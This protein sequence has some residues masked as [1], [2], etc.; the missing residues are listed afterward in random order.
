MNYNELLE[1]AK[2]L[3]EEQPTAIS[4]LSNASAFLNDVLDNLNWVGFYLYDGEVLHVGP[5]QG[6]VAC[7]TIALGSGVCG[8]AA[9]KNMTMVIPDVINH[10]N[11]IACDANSRSETVVPLFLNGKLYGVLDIDS[12]VLNRFD[13]ALVEFLEDFSKIVLKRLTNYTL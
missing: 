12:P 6:Q 5:F 4:L 7:A 1:T 8:E 9:K 3:L 11:H 13:E 2:S 10:D